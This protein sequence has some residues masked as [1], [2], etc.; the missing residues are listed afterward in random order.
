[1]SYS[2][3]GYQRWFLLTLHA[4]IIWNSYNDNAV[5][6][7]ARGFF[8]TNMSL[9]PFSLQPH[10]GLQLNQVKGSFSWTWNTTAN[11]HTRRRE[12]L[13]Q[14]CV[15]RLNLHK[16]AQKGQLWSG[17]H[18][19]WSDTTSPP[20]AAYQSCHASVY[21]QQIRESKSMLPTHPLAW[22]WSPGLSLVLFGLLGIL[23]NLSSLHIRLKTGQRMQMR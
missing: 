12:E 23:G 19:V 18:Q 21:F 3:T 22:R 6:C 11:C 17:I 20:K 4:A 9:F 10:W 13:V 16:K 14:N 5:P 8:A 2:S 15:T 7:I 1:M